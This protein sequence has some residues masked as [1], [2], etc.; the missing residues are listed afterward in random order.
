[1]RLTLSPARRDLLRTAGVAVAAFIALNLAGE[2]LRGRFETLGDWVSWPV[3]RG[4]RCALAGVV[5][6]VLAR[7]APGLR[8][9]GWLR[10]VSAAVLSAVAVLATADVVRFAGAVVRGR[11][12]TP[13][14]VPA[15]ALVAAL[16]AALAWEVTRPGE[17]GLTGTVLRRRLARA[18]AFGAVVVGLPLV[19]MVTFGPSRYERPADI[20]VVFGARVW[21]TGHPS[22]A[23]A[24]RV[25]EA[26]RLY[27]R[28]L[29]RRIVMSG[30]ID[31]QNGF[32]EPVVM[33]DRA[34]A[35]GVPRDAVV[36]DE[37]GVDTAS[38]VENTARFVREGGDGTASVL[39]VTHYYHEPRAKMLFDRAGIPAFTVPATMSRRLAKEPYFLLREVAAYYHSFLLQ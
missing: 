18:T 39:V 28:G 3:S 38:T 12:H 26:V 13:A 14:L 17:G 2:A 25:D 1:M 33:R 29:V 31:E 21:N 10:R 7:N 20:A 35:Q 19:R 30:A 16:F 22:L 37:A 4:W 8:R 11:V 6:G 36:L 23:L 32:S 27:R 24:D 5:A 15:S 9:P 34:E